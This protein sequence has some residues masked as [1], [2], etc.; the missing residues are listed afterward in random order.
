MCL[1]PACEGS[2]HNFRPCWMRIRTIQAIAI[3]PG[4]SP[5]TRNNMP[6]PARSPRSSARPSTRSSPKISCP[7]IYN[8]VTVDIQRM[9]VRHQ[10]HRRSPAAPRRRPGS[11]RRPGLTDGLRRGMDVRR[12]RL[13][14]DR[15]GRQGDARPRV[16]PARRADR[17]A[18]PG[19]RHR[20]PPDP[21]RAAGIRRPDPQDRNLR[22]RHQG[23]RPAHARS[24][25][26]ARPAC[27]AVRAWARPSS[28][29]N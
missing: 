6:A 10:P 28:S 22:D 16:Q 17:Q 11:R 7:T 29:R 13:A 20:A 19:Q 15:A 5:N 9:A 1:L 24:S 2:G 3:S 8:A 12:H 4:G 21:S 23:H 14:R 18:R 27:S 25:A 26:A